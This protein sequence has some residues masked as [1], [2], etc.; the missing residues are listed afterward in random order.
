MYRPDPLSISPSRTPGRDSAAQ[1]SGQRSPALPPFPHRRASETST[2][3]TASSEFMPATG[4][5]CAGR[6]AEESLN[7]GV[8][9]NPRRSGSGEPKL[10]PSRRHS[11]HD[12]SKVNVY[13]ECGR[14]GDDWLFGGFSVAGA[15]RKLWDKESKH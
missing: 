8:A 2:S 3:S 4:P 6:H 12:P 1:S 7:S 15:V 9:T 13:T 11:S 14:H 5:R 10:K